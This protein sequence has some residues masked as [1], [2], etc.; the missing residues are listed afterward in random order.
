MRSLCINYSNINSVLAILHLN[1]RGVAVKLRQ[2][3]S[4]PEVHHLD[5]AGLGP[6]SEAEEHMSCLKS[7]AAASMG[8]E[9]LAVAENTLHNDRGSYPM[10]G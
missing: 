1:V 6:G 3:S 7:H 8:E 9:Q 5:V 4:L 2:L 10:Q